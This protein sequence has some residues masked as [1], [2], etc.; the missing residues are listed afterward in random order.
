MIG[1]IVNTIDKEKIQNKYIEKRDL[2]PLKNTHIRK[3]SLA[4]LSP[5]FYTKNYEQKKQKTFND[6]QMYGSH[7]WSDGDNIYYS[8]IDG[9]YRINQYVLDKS[10]STW[11]T[12]TWNG[13]SSID[14]RNI[15]ADGTNIYYSNGTG[16]Y[17][18]IMNK[19]TINST[20]ATQVFV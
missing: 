8:Y 3:N 6:I 9:T 19:P 12:K 7:I 2:K 4:K 15:W 20:K 1:S 10:T 11:S 16:Q 14:G 5:I 18:I 17:K 13:L